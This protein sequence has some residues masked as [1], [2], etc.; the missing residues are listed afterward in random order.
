MAIKFPEYQLIFSF[1]TFSNLLLTIFIQGLKV[2]QILDLGPV[3]GIDMQI[4]D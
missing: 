2:A 1:K 4:V 3:I